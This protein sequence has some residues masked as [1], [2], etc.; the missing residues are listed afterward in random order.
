MT[1]FLPENTFRKAMNAIDWHDKF[2]S[3]GNGNYR[4]YNF[5]ES[6]ESLIDACIKHPYSRHSAYFVASNAEKGKVSQSFSRFY[7]SDKPKFLAMCYF[8]KMEDVTVV[9]PKESIYLLPEHLWQPRANL[10]TSKYDERENVTT[11]DGTPIIYLSTKDELEE[12]VYY[13]RPPFG[14]CIHGKV[15]KFIKTS[16]LKQWLST[17]E[18]KAFQK[19]QLMKVLERDCP[20]F[21][22]TVSQGLT[23][24]EI[25]A[26]SAQ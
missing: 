23:S 26:E 1:Q 21:H 17:K 3:D 25:I 15:S 6:I 24:K 4:P 13:L 8:P 5:S 10:V 11:K 20:K 16:D 9:L 14:H 7:N 19:E 2:Q 12:K 18:G 22:A